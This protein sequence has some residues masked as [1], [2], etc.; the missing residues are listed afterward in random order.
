MSKPT[1]LRLVRDSLAIAAAAVAIIGAT[2]RA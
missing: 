1:A 2:R